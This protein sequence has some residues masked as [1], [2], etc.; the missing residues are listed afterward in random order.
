MA[1]LLALVSAPSLETTVVRHVELLRLQPCVVMA[2]VITSTGGVAK[3]LFVFDEPVD[4]G[5]VDWAATYL[6]ETVTG[7]S[8][9]ARLLRQRLT[10]PDAAA[11][12]RGFLETIAPVFTELVE[13]RAGLYIGGTAALLSVLQSRDVESVREVVQAL[14]ERWELLRVLRDARDGGWLT[15]RIGEELSS[16]ALHPLA[17][18]AAGYGVANRKLGTVSLVG[19]TRMDYGAAIRS[20]RGAAAALS[21][22]VEELYG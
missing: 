14:E 20:V 10:T 3:R 21:E 15:I 8:L 5:L 16:P 11:R 6:N 7:L 1:N 19:P 13:P 22:F 9:G 12:E 2:V 17:F 4:P 18:V